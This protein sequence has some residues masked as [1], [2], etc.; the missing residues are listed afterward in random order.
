MEIKLIIGLILIIDGIISLALARSSRVSFNIFGLDSNSI[1]YIGHFFRILRIIFGLL[2]IFSFSSIEN[3]LLFIGLYFVLDA[4][5]SILTAK[6]FSSWDD[7][8][9]IIRIVIGSY[10]IVR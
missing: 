3:Y 4:G 6:S 7:Y 2:L 5:F 10:L 8:F 1:V 9:R